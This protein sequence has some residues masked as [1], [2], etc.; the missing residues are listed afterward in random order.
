MATSD[1]MTKKNAEPTASGN[2]TTKKKTASTTT[3]APGSKAPPKTVDERPED[4]TMA[5]SSPSEE[6]KERDPEKPPFRFKKAEDIDARTP[7]DL[8]LE[9]VEFDSPEEFL[10]DNFLNIS[11]KKVNKSHKFLSEYIELQNDENY[12]PAIAVYAHGEVRVFGHATIL[13][14][15]KIDTG[16]RGMRRG[17]EKR[18]NFP[19]EI[20]VNASATETPL[21]E[22]IGIDSIIEGL[23]KAS[24]TL[25]RHK[26]SRGPTV[27]DI[28]SILK[29]EEDDDESHEEGDEIP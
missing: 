9:H 3:P 11:L 23:W 15:D 19:G 26:E 8:G 16:G 18:V 4:T 22:K 25:D 1:E 20:A 12:H 29:L 6:E 7:F 17:K 5:K 21:V 10:D 2:K 28:L 14:S 24:L 13:E 27:E